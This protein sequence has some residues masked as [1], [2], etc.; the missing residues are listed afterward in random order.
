VNLYENYKDRVN[1]V[2][3]DLDRKRSPAQQRLV[4]Q[5]YQGYIP[6]VVVLDKSGKPLYNSS[7]EVDES[8]ISSL[9]DHQS[10]EQPGVK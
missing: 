6:H 3:V 4:K 9:L 5:Y 10:E 1:F 8:S 7:G 2:V